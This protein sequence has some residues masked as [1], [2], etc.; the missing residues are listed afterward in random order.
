MADTI[1]GQPLG[2]DDEYGASSQAPLP[3]EGPQSSGS[4]SI[5]TESNVR[6]DNDHDLSRIGVWMVSLGGLGV[7]CGGAFLVAGGILP[8]GL[9]IA[10]SLLCAF[11]GMLALGLVAH[12]QG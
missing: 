10:V 8:G 3:S 7:L 4:S 12:H 2:Q 11:V 9:V 5:Q 6:L 1:S